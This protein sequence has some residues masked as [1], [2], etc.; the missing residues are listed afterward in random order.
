MALRNIAALKAAWLRKSQRPI[1]TLGISHEAASLFAKQSIKL[2]N[3]SISKIILDHYLINSVNDIQ[4][5]I[6]TKQPNT[7]AKLTESIKLVLGIIATKIKKNST[8]GPRIEHEND[9]LICYCDVISKQTWRRCVLI[10][11]AK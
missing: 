2:T 11:R 8:V 5:R 3:I 4:A 6:I 1:A 9:F 7:S 10:L